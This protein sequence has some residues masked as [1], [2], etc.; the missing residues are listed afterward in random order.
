MFIE[1]Q[2]YVL[3]KQHIVSV[4]KNVI[5]KLS[6]NEHSIYILSI[7]NNIINVVG[8]EQEV[9]EEFKFLTKLLCETK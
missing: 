1:W 4:R 8:T 9:E 5:R 6:D 3:N 2:G 7:G